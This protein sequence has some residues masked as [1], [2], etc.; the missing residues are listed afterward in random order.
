MAKKIKFILSN[1]MAEGWFDPPEPMVRNLPTWYKDMESFHDGKLTLNG[2]ATSMTAKKCVPM[3]D[4]MSS[5][6]VFKLG[7]D[8][9]I[10]SDAEISWLVDGRWVQVHPPFQTERM[11]IGDEFHSTAFKFMNPYIIQTPKGYSTLFQHPASSLDAPFHCFSGLV[12]TDTWDLPVNFPFLLKKN[13]QGIIKKGTPLVQIIPVKRD[14]WVS[15]TGED[16]QTYPAKESKHFSQIMNY[17]RNNF[18][19]RKTFK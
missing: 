19:N 6:Y 2:K 12:D 3:M 5:G 4:A 8:I 7:F 15:E 14:D 11:P 18:W 17:Y 10:S 1:E 16:W 13:F 9:S